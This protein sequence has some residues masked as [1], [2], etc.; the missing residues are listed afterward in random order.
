MSLSLC[1]PPSPP[2]E[3]RRLRVTSVEAEQLKVS[4]IVLAEEGEDAPMTAAAAVSKSGRPSAEMQWSNDLQVRPTVGQYIRLTIVPTASA[5]ATIQQPGDA[6]EVWRVVQRL[7]LVD[8][9]PDGGRLL[10]CG[11]LLMRLSP[12]WSL[13]PHRQQT[14]VLIAERASGLGGHDTT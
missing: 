8:N 12:G 5:V 1:A 14:A 9:L 13:S 6:A 7:T 10:S 11:G 2:P 3:M 4:K